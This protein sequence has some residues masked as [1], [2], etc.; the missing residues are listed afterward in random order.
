MGTHRF[1]WFRS[2]NV[3]FVGLVL[4]GVVFLLACGTAA[5]EPTRL[6]ASLYILLTLSGMDVR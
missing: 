4:I 1:L 3:L 2:A 6:G 5:P